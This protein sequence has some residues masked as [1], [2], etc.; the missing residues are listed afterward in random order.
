MN[1]QHSNLVPFSRT[2]EYWMT[3]AGKRKNSADRS[4]ATD[5]MRHYL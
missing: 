2:P 4:T 1:R 5:G 3:R